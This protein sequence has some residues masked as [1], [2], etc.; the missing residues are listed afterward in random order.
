MDTNLDVLG[1]G[2]RQTGC[3]W[4][5]RTVNI[6]GV[7]ERNITSAT[8][9]GRMR[10]ILIGFALVAAMVCPLTAS[11]VAGLQES[12][13]ESDRFEPKSAITCYDEVLGWIR[14]WKT[15]DDYAL[16]NGCIGVWIGLR[17]SG[18]L[19]GSFGDAATVDTQNT[20]NRALTGAVRKAMYRATE[21][22]KGNDGDAVERSDRVARLREVPCSLEMQFAHDPIRLRA[23]TVGQIGEALRPGIDGVLLRIGDRIHSI[24]PVEMVL[25]DQVPSSAI[26]SL[27]ANLGL[28][29]GDFNA[30]LSDG[31]IRA[32]RFKV[33]HLAQESPV[34]PATI[35]HRGSHIVPLASINAPELSAFA[36]GLV[37]HLLASLWPGEEP[38]GIMGTYMADIDRFDPLTATTADQAL[39]AFALAHYASWQDS[40]SSSKTSKARDAAWDIVNDLAARSSIDVQAVRRPGAAAVVILALGELAGTAEASTKVSSLRRQCL[41]L[42]QSSFDTEKNQ[43]DERV[44]VSEQVVCALVL[45]TRTAV[46][47]VWRTTSFENQPSVLPWLGW[48]E[49][50]LAGPDGP[51]AAATGLKTLRMRLW[52]TQVSIGDAPWG[53]SDV[54]GGLAFR[55][56]QPP[57]WNTARPVTFLATM[58]GDPRL[59]SSDGD[60]LS[61]EIVNLLSA[62]RFLRQLSMREAD[63]YRIHDEKRALNGIRASL[64]S[65]R[66][67]VAASA[68]TLIAVTEFEKSLS[69]IE[70][71]LRKSSLDGSRRES[72]VRR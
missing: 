55:G 20:S 29:I 46:D 36:D 2:C 3:G 61:T 43:F 32:W 70:A 9:E 4:M 30:Q 13:D 71:R 40:R 24:F 51:I 12:E 5:M 23:T 26:E 53:E 72:G 54:Q 28:A 45:G 50:R 33:F 19:M 56:S 60:E 44:A 14:D 62:M 8:R 31:R 65:D 6:V 17:W 58:V 25:N 27:G 38:L 15:P 21:R 39:A 68:M 69:L 35:L 1:R 52:G 16:P 48:A 59:T 63:R 34:E 37:D 66:E 10:K 64:W 22:A 49:Q 7:P 42:V 18:R 57:D 67:P 11:S 47:A 41:N